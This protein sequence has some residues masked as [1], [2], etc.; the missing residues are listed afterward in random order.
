MFAMCCCKL[1]LLCNYCLLTWFFFSAKFYV[2]WFILCLH[3]AGECALCM[4]MCHD[5][6]PYTY[7]LCNIFNNELILVH[8]Q[9]SS[10]ICQS[11][12]VV[13]GDSQTAWLWNSRMTKYVLTLAYPCLIIR[14]VKFIA[15]SLI[16][17]RQ[18][19]DNF[20]YFFLLSTRA[21][22]RVG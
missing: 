10:C 17:T 12:T 9:C 4:R 21:S 11:Y 2:F 19:K 7:L 22:R 14:K 5:P 6:C 8:L 16:C 20:L 18:G 3:N 13:H 1:A 15:Y